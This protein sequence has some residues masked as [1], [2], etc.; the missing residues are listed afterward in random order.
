MYCLSPTNQSS[1]DR[2]VKTELGPSNVF[3]LPAGTMLNSV[4]RGLWKDI[5]CKGIPAG[6]HVP[7]SV[8][9]ALSSPQWSAASSTTLFRQFYSRVLP[10]RHHLQH[11][12]PWH[13]K[14]QISSKFQNVD[15]QQ[16]HRHETT[17]T[18]VPLVNHSWG[19]GGGGSS[20]RTQCQS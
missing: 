2:S 5:H 15:I 18:S 6:S 17:T 1:I 7:C 10:T 14:K 13:L 3:P 11:S 8:N 9:P 19:H 20:L 16:F 12:F 4:S